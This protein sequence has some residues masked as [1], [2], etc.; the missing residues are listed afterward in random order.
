MQ[1]DIQ[2]V[3]PNQEDDEDEEALRLRI[4]ISEA[5][6]KLKKIEARK[7][8][9]LEEQ[10][11][12]ESQRSN[13]E[14][15]LPRS[16]SALRSHRGDL[17]SVR[18]VFT[19][20]GSSGNTQVPAS[21][22]KRQEPPVESIS[23]G[24]VVLGIDKG[25]KGRNVSLR[26]PPTQNTPSSIL[27]DPFAT[28][29]LSRTLKS[30]NTLSR[31]LDVPSEAGPN[32]KTFSERIAETRQQDKDD[33]ARAERVRKHRSQGFGIEQR[34]L[35]MLRDS[36]RNE[37][38]LHESA[39]AH[40]K[41]A[42]D[43]GFSRDQ[44]MQAVSKPDGGLIQRSKST[45][46][47]QNT[48]RQD[49]QSASSS[50]TYTPQSQ[51]LTKPRPEI[52]V[53]RPTPISPSFEDPPSRPATPPAD[54]SLFEP[55]S[56]LHLSKRLI[57]HNFLTRTLKSKQ[58]LLLPSLLRQVKSPDYA[59]PSSYDET[60][61]VVFGIL[62]SKSSPLSHKDKNKS[63]KNTASETA[64]SLQEADSSREN[65]SGKYLALTLTDL[66]WSI[67]LYL[68]TT[69]YTQ[70]RKL[71]PGTVIAVLNPSIMPP[72]P[73]RKDTG[74]FSLTLSSSD[75]TILEVGNS[76]DLG[77]CK[78][79]KKDG[80][81]CSCWVDKRHTEFCEWHVDKGV[82]RCRRGRMEV[83]GMS[84]PFGPGG[85]NKGRTGFFGGKRSGGGGDGHGTGRWGGDKSFGESAG[86][87]LRKEG[88][89]YDKYIGSK[90]FVAPGFGSGRG[91]AS[92]LD[93]DSLGARGMNREELTRRR[94]AERERE[95]E[96]ARKLGEGGHGLGGE[97]L[98]L[99]SD[100]GPNRDFQEKEGGFAAQDGVDAG[101]L[102]LLGNRAREVK[103]SPLKKKR[104]NEE[105][106]VGGNGTGTEMGTGRKKTRFV[107]PNGIREAGRESF[108]AEDGIVG[109]T[110][111]EEDDEDDLNIV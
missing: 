34:D 70:F 56:A 42:R 8:K 59:L 39:T 55:F 2:H 24:R 79:V 37:S 97:Y 7:A 98:R 44:V 61:F 82:E 102:G 101:S 69:A 35:D 106:V 92:L 64:T 76:R 40:K 17:H 15:D 29:T 12:P 28:S 26:R 33:K 21:P 20:T 18:P 62:A 110:V 13:K 63:T 77:F 36:S 25:L 68:F 22:P 71:S 108:G 38:L 104:R 57:P 87:G 48:R 80:H 99:R 45:S 6:L 73:S 103:L 74:Q 86:T 66:T 67:D 53:S 94:L 81:V 88:A 109:K 49:I 19:R 75:D 27:E 43:A 4:E 96:V 50:L 31:K 14:N 1:K 9:T 41:P 111:E 72:P 105:G 16:A 51:L 54:A 10:P 89:Q 100:N 46:G 58:I 78:A 90:F 85:K 95:K 3:I 52:K 93:D 5:R 11:R 107:T 60:D 65:N 84:A 47:V 32:H 30:S 91:A 23:P 83:Q